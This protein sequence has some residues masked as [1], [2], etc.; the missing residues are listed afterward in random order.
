[1][2]KKILIVDDEEEFLKLVGGSLTEKGYEVI[3]STTAEDGMDKARTLVPDL[4]LFDII[5]PD[6]DGSEAVRILSEDP[7][8]ENIP[9]IFVSGI[10]T[11]TEKGKISDLRVGG[12]LYK[13]FSK[14]FSFES[15]MLEVRK[16]IG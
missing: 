11:G 15:L 12:R 16:I 13:A 3:L 6:M 8:T 5:L 9:V 14:P 10:V 7:L 1:M 2:S 4:I